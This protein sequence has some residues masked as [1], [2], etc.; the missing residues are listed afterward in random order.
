MVRFR[1]NLVIAGGIPWAED[2]WRRLRMGEAEFRAVKGCDRCA[3]P[4]TDEETAVRGKEPT[5]TLAKHRRWDGAVWFGMNVVPLTPGATLHVGD[6]VEVLD[7]AADS[8]RPAALIVES[9]TRVRGRLRVEVA[10]RTLDRAVEGRIGED[11]RPQSGDGHGGVDGHREV[12]DDLAAGRA[13][14]RGA[15][16]YAAIGVLDHLDQT[17]G[18]GAVGEAARGLLE[19]G[20]AGPDREPGSPLPAPRSSRRRRPRD[21]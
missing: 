8:G 13:D 12:A 15:D 18:T 10:Q 5:Y 20:A 14:D 9:L 7:S 6:P 2:G 11:H 19:L 3:I 16:E 17:A 4:T 1:P 21:R